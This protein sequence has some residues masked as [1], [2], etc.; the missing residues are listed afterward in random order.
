MSLKDLNVDELRVVFN[1]KMGFRSD[2]IEGKK[3]FNNLFDIKETEEEIKKK[4]NLTGPQMIKYMMKI[5]ELK[6]LEAEKKYNEELKLKENK[7]DKQYKEIVEDVKEIKKE[8]KED[9]K[10]LKQ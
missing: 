1:N 8:F 4:K 6:D 2:N 3:K 7:E 10:I 9:K 5:N